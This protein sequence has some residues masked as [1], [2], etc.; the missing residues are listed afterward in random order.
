MALRRRLITLSAVA[1]L[2][3]MTL[4]AASP[5]RFERLGHAMMCSCGCN[6]VLLECNH[7][8]C[9][10][11]DGMRNEL[12]SA[13]AAGLSDSAVLDQFVSKYGPPILAAP[14]KTGF[15]RVAWIT[16]FAILSFAII[17]C[18]YLVRTWKTRAVSHSP[19]APL[20]EDSAEAEALRRR[21]REE[22]DLEK[23][24]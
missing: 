1:L 11:S 19:V 22:T 7:V 21:A 18:V 10:A 14:L 12:S 9:P 17:G 16:P 8:G 4:G 3:L 20:P 15:G 24:L 2:A 23:K 6:Q 5:E 13:L